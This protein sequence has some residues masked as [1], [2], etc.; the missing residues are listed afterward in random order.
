M[1][2]P[3]VPGCVDKFHDFAYLRQINRQINRNSWE[4]KDL[5]YCRKCLRQ[6]EVETKAPAP[7]AQNL[8]LEAQGYRP[9]W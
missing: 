6:V 4:R 3:N 2:S 1:A 7:D 8:T 9:S 5:F